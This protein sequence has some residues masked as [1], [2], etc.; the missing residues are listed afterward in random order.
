M[1]V[2]PTRNV[3]FWNMPRAPEYDAPLIATWRMYARLHE[4]L[5]DYSHQLAS[6]AHASGMPIIR[7][8]FIVEPSAP[9]A[10]NNW[11]TYEYG[12]D[13]VVSPVW[14]KGARERQVYLPTGNRWRNA[15][16]P[17]QVFDGGQTVTVAAE[18]HQLPLFIREGSALQL[19]DLNREWEESRAAAGRK[20]DLAVLE[21]TVTQWFARNGRGPPLF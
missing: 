4:R 11:W 18:A 15:W 21:K 1:E 8:M 20:P 6:E 14:Q 19:G 16:K 10:W 7:P 3:A 17:D 12:P 5:R 9:A 13:L 2:G